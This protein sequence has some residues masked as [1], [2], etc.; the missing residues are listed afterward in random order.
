MKELSQLKEKLKAYGINKHLSSYL[1][2]TSWRT[3]KTIKR[4]L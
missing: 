3:C 4:I 2:R 1:K